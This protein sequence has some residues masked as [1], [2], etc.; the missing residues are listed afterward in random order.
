MNPQL[1]FD[2]KKC[3]GC[4]K[5]FEICLQKV[6]RIENDAHILDRSLCIECGA[7]A[8]HCYAESLEMIGKNATVSEIMEEVSKDKVFYE[9]SDGGMTVSGGEPLAQPEFTVALLKE[10]K[11][12]GLHTVVETC[13]FAN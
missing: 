10:A 5:C 8:E 13:G 12:Q 4:G 1:F 9:S 7:C 6:H 11:K 3:V 2:E